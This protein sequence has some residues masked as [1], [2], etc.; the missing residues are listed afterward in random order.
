MIAIRRGELLTTVLGG[1]VVGVGAGV[2]GVALTVRGLARSAVLDAP[3]V[4]PRL[5]L[6]PAGWVLFAGAVLGG[7][8]VAVGYGQIVGR[9]AGT[10]TPVRVER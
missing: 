4:T 2:V 7:V 6:A 5:L 3:A 9:Q 10:A 8:A 1:A